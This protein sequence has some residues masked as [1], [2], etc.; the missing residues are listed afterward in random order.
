MIRYIILKMQHAINS[1][2]ELL[3]YYIS[4]FLRKALLTKTQSRFEIYLTIQINWKI[5]LTFEA[6]LENPNFN[7]LDLPNL[8]NEIILTLMHKKGYFLSF[9]GH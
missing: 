8:P 3:I 4:D 5:S 6:F 1:P 7:G 9:A 2:T